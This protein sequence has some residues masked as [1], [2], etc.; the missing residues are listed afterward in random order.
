MPDD[1]LVQDFLEA[2]EDERPLATSAEPPTPLTPKEAAIAAYKTRNAKVLV[3]LEFRKVSA[4]YLIEKGRL[5]YLSKLKGEVDGDDWVQAIPQLASRNSRR[6]ERSV[7]TTVG[8]IYRESDRVREMEV[9]DFRVFRDG[10]LFVRA[11]LMDAR[12]FTRLE[13]M[14]S[15]VYGKKAE[16]YLDWGEYVALVRRAEIEAQEE[17]DAEFRFDSLI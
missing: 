9:G 13:D 16:D 11:H 12:G 2:W 5:V 10:N 3:D 14:S 4:V 6:N 7:K 15:R 17:E 8:H 1:N